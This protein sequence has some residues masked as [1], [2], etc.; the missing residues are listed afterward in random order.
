MW[1]STTRSP[2]PWRPVKGRVLVVDASQ[3]IEA[4][5]LA[6]TYLALEHDLEI[7]PVINKIDLPAADPERVGQRDRGCHRHRRLDAPCISAKNGHQYRGGAGS[8]SS[9]DI[10]PRPG[11]QNAPL[12][13][14]IFDSYYDSYKG[15]IVYIRVK[16]GTRPAR[17]CHPH[18][19]HRR[20][21]RRG[22]SRAIMG[23]TGR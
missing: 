10:P 5:T 15:V 19:G 18:D 22:G 20:R 2:A 14:L 12:Q 8:G 16:E 13:A 7:V 23:A 4:Q 3:G 9:H 17:R 1:T 11:I 6:N 21:I